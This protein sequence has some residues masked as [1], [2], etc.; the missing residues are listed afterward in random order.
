MLVHYKVSKSLIY[1]LEMTVSEEGEKKRIGA[2]LECLSLGIG[3]A[4]GG[5][6]YEE[7]APHPYNLRCQSRLTK[8]GLFICYRHHGSSCCYR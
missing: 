5:E 4:G 1:D 2:D 7:D 3:A 8:F 6:S